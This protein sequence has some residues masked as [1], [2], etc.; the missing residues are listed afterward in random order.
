M[1]SSIVRKSIWGITIVAAIV[2]LVVAAL[3][4]I[5]STRLVRDRIALE[6]SAL[7]GYRVEL[8]SAPD[9]HIWPTFSAVLNDVSLSDWDD[10]DRNP[11]LDAESVELELSP[12]AALQGNV[13]IASAR[14][15]RPVLYVSE[16]APNRYA[17]VAPRFGRVRHAIEV[18]QALVKANPR[19]PDVSA[20]D[21]GSFGTVEFS[22]GQIVELD[23]GDNAALVTGLA[24]AVEWGALDDAAILSASGVWR[25]ENFSLD[26]S[27]SRP[28]ILFAGGSAPLSFN[29]KAAPGSGSF[30][31]GV[32][33]DQRQRQ[34]LQA[35]QRRDHA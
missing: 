1:P 18:A 2:V 35:R 7:S 20:L 3:P 24:G 25:G 27:S 15:V 32:G 5:A 33:K 31:R 22:D 28:L 8:A 19:N 16:V 13:R 10:P 14:L 4:W 21:D 9:V 17:P 34:P 26:A 11:V 29:L 6:M 23:G 12:I 30:D